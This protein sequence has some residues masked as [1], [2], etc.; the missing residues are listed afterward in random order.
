MTRY[1][2]SISEEASAA[3]DAQATYIAVD[4]RSPLNSARWL[5]RVMAAVRALQ[6]MPDRFGVDQ[7]ETLALGREVRRLVFERTYRLFYTIDEP[8]QHVAI[9]I[10]RHGARDRPPRS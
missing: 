7:E 1:T 6:V 2:T 9:V 10:F 4:Q 3:I 5:A 8:Q